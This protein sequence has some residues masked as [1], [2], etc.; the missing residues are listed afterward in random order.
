[1]YYVSWEEVQFK[2]VNQNY[3]KKLWKIPI[4][5][6]KLIML[7]ITHCLSEIWD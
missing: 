5:M 3:W 6:V 4:I 1:M 7:I 2:R